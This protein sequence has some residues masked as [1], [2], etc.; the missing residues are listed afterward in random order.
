MNSEG[1][2][3]QDVS[4]VPWLG[5]AR[6]GGRRVCVSVSVTQGWQCLETSSLTYG[7]AVGTDSPPA[8][9]KSPPP[10]SSC[11]SWL[12]RPHSMVDGLPERRERERERA[13]RT[14]LC[15]SLWPGSLTVS[16]PLY[17]LVQGSHWTWHSY[18]M[19]LS[20]FNHWPP[21]WQSD[22]CLGHWKGKRLNFLLLRFP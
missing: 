16:P 1:T 4:A 20:S 14:A 11:S 15:Q 8:P 22:S 6:K 17:P 5:P 3:E 18:S 21:T 19:A 13:L 12:R 7:L 10:G 2:E 9:C